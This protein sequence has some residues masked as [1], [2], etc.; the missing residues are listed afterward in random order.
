MKE[1][2]AHGILDAYVARCARRLRRVTAVRLAA[3]ALLGALA[4]AALF[5]AVVVYW[6]PGSA[7]TVTAR[8]LLAIVAVLP[9]AVAWRMRG[10]AGGP[11]E[12]IERLV[13]RFDGRLTTWADA[14]RRG[15]DSR[16]L[17]VLAHETASVAGDHS[18]SAVVPA[19]RFVPWSLA[20]AGAIAGL[21]WLLVAA[22]TAWQLAGQRLFT[23]ALF[24]DGQPR[25]V[26]QPGDA[27]VPRG[28]DV[29]V[30]ATPWGFEPGA[31]RLHAAFAGGSGWERADMSPAGG[32]ASEFVLVA[33]TEPVE[34]Y[35]SAGSLNSARFR[36]DV[37]DLPAVET[38]ALD[39][40][41]PE[42]TGVSPTRQFEGDVA[43]VA[44]TRVAVE[45]A[46]D[47]PLTGA[48]LVR[49]GVARAM[50]VAGRVGT[51]GFEID[52]A[53][54]WHLAVA[55]QGALVRITE[56]FAIDLAVDTPPEI[57]FVFPGRD[58]SVTSIEELA[59]RF[60]ARDD[61]GVE[62]LALHYSVNGGA[63]VQH[64]LLAERDTEVEGGTLL[65]F[66]DLSTPEGAPEGAPAGATA[67][68]MRPGDVVSFF[69]EARDRE[70]STRSALYFADVRPFD[71]RYRERQSQGGGGGGGQGIDIAARQRDI[72][73]A[74][75]N[76]ILERDRGER[77]G[78]EPSA[79]EREGLAPRT[80][81]IADRTDVL[82]LL[83]ERLMEQIDTLVARSEGRGLSA[84]AEID[85]FVTELAQAREYM[86]PAAERLAAH[87]LD[88]ALPLEQKALQ[89]AL[90]AE[91]GLREMNVSL[92]SESTGSGGGMDRS[93]SELID[94]EMDPERNRYEMPRAPGGQEQG[95][96]DHAEWER[97]AELAR[98]QEAL[99]RSA[100]GQ[101]MP[102][103]RWRQERLRREVEE[104][105]Q[106]LAQAGG[107]RTGRIDDAIER[108]GEARDAIDDSLEGR[109]D[110][111]QQ[112]RI[113][114]AL[115][116]AAERLR[117]AGRQRS[118]EAIEEA[119]RDVARLVRTQQG[120]NERLQTLQDESLDAS[121]RGQRT[122]NGLRN[123][124][125]AALDA[126]TD[127]NRK[128]RMREDFGE[129]VRR[130]EELRP[131]LP[132]REGASLERAL[133]DVSDARLV[134]RMAAAAE[135]FDR[136]RPLFLIGQE[137]YVEEALGRFG[138]RLGRLAARLA[139]RADGEPPEPGLA[140][141]Q[142]LRRSLEQA[143]AGE[144]ARAMEQVARAVTV[145]ELEVLGPDD[146]PDLSPDRARYR[147]LG[148]SDANA[149]RLYRMTIDRL[150]RLEVALARS[151][152]TGIRAE[153]P[154]D[155]AY[156]SEEVARYFRTLS[157]GRE[158]R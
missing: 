110:P 14:R 108:L 9:F 56:E 98:R 113:A 54:A 81:K 151:G 137:E 3:I 152:R 29:V 153:E 112:E 121:R 49:D 39:V 105:R 62:G 150:D 50:E 99:A 157:C 4:V 20:A 34:Y 140:R 130:L 101:Q 100:G 42:W 120:I 67:R 125:A 147:A 142:E 139:A 92:A 79:G 132:E 22:P 76:L 129:I 44:G 38:L 80:K 109:G 118:V 69:A 36:V 68:A 23:G 156:D 117:D 19:R 136:G 124:A 88:E 26:V 111:R 53:G 65:M 135:V 57:E 122:P 138:D 21:A 18:P 158:C 5:A 28:S 58:R 70:Q 144:D 48:H 141:A 12:R 10:G 15:R 103:S 61:F 33:V 11:A 59:L 87:A 155:D 133:D 52:R 7:W 31:M 75:W 64:E 24:A 85:V 51:A 32:D 145:M 146:A 63:A 102:V 106:R 148:T 60:R 1:S 71:R 95:A 77:V 104:M 90:A 89:H 119:R 128:R 96:E 25:I 115:R 91:A 83:Q 40:T 2:A 107:G 27:V 134:E 82:A 72:V 47:L 94:L 131:S 6:V 116:E 149:E 126:A 46:A 13:P 86:V 97:L 123:R 35:V 43:G 37:A 74:T 114:D 93:L 78:E 30:R 55:H 154:R 16:L 41:W 45:A 66:E 17:T 8:V 73:T 143:A 127:A 84:S